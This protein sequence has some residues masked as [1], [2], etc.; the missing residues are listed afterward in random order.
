MTYIIID[1]VVWRHAHSAQSLKSR[2]TTFA[3]TILFRYEEVGK[4]FE[5]YIIIYYV[6]NCLF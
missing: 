6:A 3:D 2:Q 1:D 5:V 4:K